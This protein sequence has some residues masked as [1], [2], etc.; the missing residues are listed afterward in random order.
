MSAVIRLQ[1]I[2]CGL[3]FH[4]VHILIVHSVGINADIGFIKKRETIAI[5]NE[6][7]SIWTMSRKSEKRAEKTRTKNKPFSQIEWE[8][9]FRMFFSLRNE[10]LRVWRTGH[11]SRLRA[12]RIAKWSA[13][14]NLVNHFNGSMCLLLSLLLLAF[15]PEHNTVYAVP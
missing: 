11:Y 4:I 2:P 8:F 3:F 6:M 12:M 9:F 10:W 1:V 5:S 14:Q 7:N 13:W 15:V